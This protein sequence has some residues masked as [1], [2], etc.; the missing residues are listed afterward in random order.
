MFGWIKKRILKSIIKDV[1][2][3]LPQYKEQALLYIEMHKDEVIEK[4]GKAI[5]E[6]IKNE[7]AK[8]VNK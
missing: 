7:I 2:K 6:I 5:A 8:V 1:A 3:K 4:V